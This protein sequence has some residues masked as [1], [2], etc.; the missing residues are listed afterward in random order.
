M[1][2]DAGFEPSM[3]GAID[4]WRRWRRIDKRAVVFLMK[5]HGAGI[6][7]C[8]NEGMISIVHK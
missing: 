7:S 1:I 8:R 4:R 2:H 5:I 3:Q 6:L